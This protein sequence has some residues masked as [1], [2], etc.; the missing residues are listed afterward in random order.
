[1]VRKRATMTKIRIGVI[2]PDKHIRGR[3]V[4]IN[5]EWENITIQDI[6]PFLNKGETIHGYCDITKEVQQ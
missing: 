5:K 3:E 2:M 1:M 4:E 6:L